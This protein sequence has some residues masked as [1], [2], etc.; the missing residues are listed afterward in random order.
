MSR[1][2]HLTIKGVFG[3]KP[4]SEVDAMI[5]GGDEGVE[6]LAEKKLFKL[7]EQKRRAATRNQPKKT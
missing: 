1:S 7:E 6:A 4:A 3:G 2:R 5:D